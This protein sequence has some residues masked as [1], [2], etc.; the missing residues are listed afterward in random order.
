MY[1][2]YEKDEK[3]EL[4]GDLKA[5]NLSVMLFI[6]GGSNAGGTSAYMDGS[7]LAASGHVIVATINFRLDVL[8]FFN[9]KERGEYLS[10][11]YGL[12]DQLNAIKWLH[13]NCENIGK[14]LIK[15]MIELEKTYLLY[16]LSFNFKYLL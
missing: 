7:A 4:P 15:Q 10:G 11:H 8:G 1:I 14:F 9:L 2:P 3:L 6:H 16:L 12:W 13:Q 5:R